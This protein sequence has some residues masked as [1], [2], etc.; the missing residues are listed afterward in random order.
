[1][2]TNRTGRWGSSRTTSRSTSRSNSNRSSSTGARSTTRPAPGYQTIWNNFNNKVSSYKFLTAQASG[3]AK[4]SRP[5]PA[6]L[7]TFGKWIEKGYMVQKVTNA[8]LKRWANTSKNYTTATSAK[9]AIQKRFGK[10]P[11]K[12]VICNKTGGF[13][14]ATSPMHKGKTFKFPS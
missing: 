7:N 10:T 1:M 8:Q 11:I 9:M 6:A 5:T 2:P 14:V 13:L 4:A 12:A 3:P